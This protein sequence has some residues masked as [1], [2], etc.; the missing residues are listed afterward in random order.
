MDLWITRALHV[1]SSGLF[2]QRITAN[3]LHILYA[4]EKFSTAHCVPIIACTPFNFT[5]LSH[6]LSL[7]M[8]I[9][10]YWLHFRGHARGACT[11]YRVLSVDEH[12]SLLKGV[13]RIYAYAFAACSHY[14]EYFIWQCV[15]SP[16][17]S[18]VVG[19][20]LGWLAGWCCL[21]VTSVGQTDQAKVVVNDG[22]HLQTT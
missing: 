4:D 7:Y 11:N 13:G 21:L 9:L 20:S 6:S 5:P 3:H 18:S 8:Y 12:E 14:F 17:S 15:S 2:S 10:N 22:N 1:W 19:G 16:S